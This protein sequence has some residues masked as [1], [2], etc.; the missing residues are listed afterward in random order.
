MAAL[1]VWVHC[2]ARGFRD[3]VA[4]SPE[5]WSLWAP[6]EAAPSPKVSCVSHGGGVRR[7]RVLATSVFCST[8][9]IEQAYTRL[10]LK[11]KR[12][13]PPPPKPTKKKEN[14][15]PEE[16]RSVAS[17]RVS[18][19]HSRYPNIGAIFQRSPRLISSRTGLLRYQC[20]RQ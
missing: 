10:I 12:G 2:V 3:S 6:S 19:V 4:A 8:Q 5:W 14:K 9:E 20:D 15:N 13:A 7:Q 1:V 17:I 11:S 16:F 18:H